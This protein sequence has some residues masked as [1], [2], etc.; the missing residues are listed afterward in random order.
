M[1][2]AR[3]SESWHVR[4]RQAVDDEILGERFRPQNT[5]EE[6]TAVLEALARLD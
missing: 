6:L 5:E 4:Q 3:G 1:T 2:D